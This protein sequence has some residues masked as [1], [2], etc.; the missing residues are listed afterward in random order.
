MD[1]IDILKFKTFNSGSIDFVEALWKLTNGNKSAA[2]DLIREDAASY[3]LTNLKDIE[4]DTC[5]DEINDGMP[6]EWK[7]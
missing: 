4:I 5:L 1:T 2:Y 7:E 3:G 6:V